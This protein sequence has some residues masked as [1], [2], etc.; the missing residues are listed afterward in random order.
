MESVRTPAPACDRARDTGGAACQPHA[1]PTRLAQTGLPSSMLTALLSKHLLVGG[2]ASVATLADSTTLHPDVIDEIVA[3]MLDSGHLHAQADADGS[4]RVG[5]NPAG[6]LFACAALGHDGYVGPAPVSAA[7]YALVVTANALARDPIT[8]QILH[9]AFEGVVVDERTIDQFAVALSSVKPLLVHGPSGAGKTYLC[10][11]LARALRGAT[12]VPHAVAAG[13]VAVRVYDPALHDVVD[14]GV[15]TAG[16]GAVDP[17]FVCCRRPALICG[18]RL[19]RARLDVSIDPI[20]NVAVAPLTMRANNGML[21]VDD[22]G[23]QHITLDEL[24]RRWALPLDTQRDWITVDGSR[25]ESVPFDVVLV[26]IANRELEGVLPQ[27]FRRHLGQRIALGEVPAEHYLL[28]WGRACADLGIAFDAGLARYALTGLHA[29]EGVPPLAAHPAQLLAA[30]VEHARR[31]DQGGA[32]T[33]DMLRA[34][35]S[36]RFSAAVRADARS[37]PR[38]E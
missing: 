12:L 15:T 35:W 24:S 6:R 14:V 37:A 30:M 4:L 33:R 38:P 32:P 16:G 34:A 20:T 8:P 28:L 25:G 27:D 3:L 26:L 21:I 9:A 17:R 36:A 10:Q 1:A 2:A 19:D 7:Q 23:D 5:L 22:F 13:D 29:A 18:A 11:H 31:N